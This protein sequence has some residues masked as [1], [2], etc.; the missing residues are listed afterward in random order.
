MNPRRILVM[1]VSASGKSTVGNRLASSLGVE[2]LDAD[3]FHS[4]ANRAKMHEGIPLEESDRIP[5]LEAI[6]AAIR[7]K[8][9]FVLACSALRECYRT[10]LRNACPDL[11]II[12]LHGSRE[13]LLERIQ[14]RQGHFMP[15]SLLD[16][17]LAT[18]E[19]PM[20]A[21]ALDIALSPSEIVSRL[22]A[23]WR[24]HSDSPPDSM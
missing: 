4:E 11:H 17:Q 2:F 15:A 23:A 18:L 9:A 14:Q 12:F 5:W 8:P 7:E 3:D 1:G 10:Y 6:A 19:I 24:R 22:G 21:L 13:T 16:S 20:G